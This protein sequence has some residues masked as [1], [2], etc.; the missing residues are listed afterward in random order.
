M[1]SPHDYHQVDAAPDMDSA[2]PSDTSPKGRRRLRRFA[3]GATALSALALSGCKLSRYGAAKPVTTQAHE[4]VKLW[5]LFFIA[6]VVIFV[7]VLLL[8]IWAA[9]RYR[10][11]NEAM[12]RQFQ[13]NNLIEIIYT[14][15]PIAIVGVLFAFTFVAEN[16]V[17]ALPKQTVTVNVTAFQWGW[18]FQ[19]PGYNTRVIG[20]ENQDPEMVLPTNENVRI[21]LRAADVI[22][23]FYVPAFD[24]SRYALPGV[25]NQFDV[26][27]QHAGIYRGQCTQ[28]CGIYHSLML[29]RVKAVSPSQ[30]DTWVTTHHNN[31]TTIKSITQAKS[32]IKAS[33]G[34]SQ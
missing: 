8:I 22:H 25:T 34:G 32:Q 18:Q 30:F 15:L 14:A 1:E 17:D 16:K 24:F 20:I 4:A 28:L 6:G 26:N 13:Y 10:R 7:I 11:R 33:L 27:I 5:Q 12:P 31:T 29:F 21:Y 9:F 23:G 3:I 19:Y 2:S